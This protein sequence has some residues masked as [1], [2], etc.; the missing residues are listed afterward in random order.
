[1]NHII[2]I[3]VLSVILSNL[4]QNKSFLYE[5]LEILRVR[6]YL[7]VLNRDFMQ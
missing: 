2:L 6:Y 1:M 3:N 4:T 7:Y 5:F